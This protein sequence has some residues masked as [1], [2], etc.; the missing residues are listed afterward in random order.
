M[1]NSID[2][3]AVLD[4]LK[5]VAHFAAHHVYE[6]ILLPVLQ[7]LSQNGLDFDSELEKRL[8]FYEFI[9][10]CSEVNYPN[11]VS[12]EE[13]LEIY[14]KLFKKYFTNKAVK[15]LIFYDWVHI[16][17]KILLQIG[18][19]SL[20]KQLKFNF[21]EIT[22]ESKFF[23]LPKDFNMIMFEENMKVMLGKK[24]LDFPATIGEKK[25]YDNI[26]RD[27]TFKKLTDLVEKNK[28]SILKIHTLYYENSIPSFQIDI[29]GFIRKLESLILPIPRISLINSILKDSTN[30]VK[31]EV[32]STAD[33]S[34]KKRQSDGP[35]RNENVGEISSSSDV[36]RKK[37][38]TDEISSNSSKKSRLNQTT[39]NSP[40]VT[41]S[42]SAVE[43]L[44]NAQ[45]VIKKNSENDPLNNLID[46]SSRSV[47]AKVGVV[48]KQSN[49]SS[50]SST[51]VT[52]TTPPRRCSQR[53]KDAQEAK[54]SSQSSQAPTKAPEKALP[55]P[56]L[57]RKALDGP[58]SNPTKVTPMDDNGDDI[59]S[60]EEFQTPVEKITSRLNIS[61]HQKKEFPHKL[62]QNQPKSSKFQQIHNGRRKWTL[63]EE[64]AVVQGVQIH[65]HNWSHIL[66]DPKFSNR[67][68]GRTN[69][70]IKDKWRNLE[71][72][73]A[74]TD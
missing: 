50:D 49:K 46:S 26:F 64:E 31:Q 30:F 62:I 45:K 36:K 66:D 55:S 51:L 40:A 57:N 34:E 39:T 22:G 25:M 59:S 73:A 61:G 2:H 23:I 56:S 65:G 44:Q 37:P 35:Y 28:L 41:S 48:A 15:E 47:V 69:V 14:D 72:A 1:S 21:T 16:R 68:R 27:K 17:E 20:Y 42:K 11:T 58:R 63:D 54:D 12:F 6:S 8:E 10:K 18:L 4:D 71:K 67:L 5:S 33:W 43:N 38:S 24:S 9:K 7:Q 53:N 60:D 19:S 29:N 3:I 32:N 13:L 52:V 74:I 70:N